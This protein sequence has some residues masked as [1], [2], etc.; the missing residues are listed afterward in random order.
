MNVLSLFTGAGGL[1][2][3]L[4]AAGFDIIGC[5]EKDADARKTLQYNRPKWPLARKR[6]IHDYPPEDLLSEFR[7]GERELTIIS[8]GPPCQPFSKSGWWANGSSRRME[9][10]RA[11]T[12]RALLNITE[13]ALP[14]ILIIENVAGLIY[15]GKDEA[16][17]EV[18][19]SLERINGRRGT[20][21]S[22]STLR[23]R[24]DQYGVPQKRYRVFLLAC[25]EG[26]L[27]AAPRPTHA[28][29]SVTG[30]R[31]LT[32]WDAI[33]HLDGSYDPETDSVRLRGQWGELVPSI[34]EGQNYLW[35]TTRGGGQPLFGWRT[36]YWTF[37]LKLAK[38][39]PAW[40]IQA[41]TGPATGPFHW[42]NRR[43]AVEEL[44]RLQTFPNQYRIEGPDPSAR[45]QVGNAVPAAIGELIGLALKS[46]VLGVDADLRL[47]LLPARRDDCPEP[48]PTAPVPTKYLYLAKLEHRAHPGT[49]LGPSALKRTAQIGAPQ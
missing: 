28:S 14:E 33:G 24:S 43:L 35:H 2:L 21:Y 48:E 39:Q 31:E 41:H 45:R 18:Q 15:A 38:Q 11:D 17:A 42:K 34:P 25:R 20:R 27:V 32:A 29:S 36:R 8:A 19:Q 16:V 40:T 46:Q 30:E 26:A 22:L 44:C 10:S 37:L 23:I 47:S 4:E 1:D 49:G 9:D 5:V 13:A 3:G 7:I 12:L 6:D